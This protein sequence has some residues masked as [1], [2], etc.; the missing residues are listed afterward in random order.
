[1]AKTEVGIDTISTQIQN[2]ENIVDKID[3]I[4]PKLYKIRQ[5][6][7]AQK[8]YINDI[9]MKLLKDMTGN[10]EGKVITLGNLH[11]DGDVNSDVSLV[12][13]PVGDETGTVN[14]RKVIHSLF[15]FKHDIGTS[16]HFTTEQIGTEANRNNGFNL[17]DVVDF[18]TGLD[19]LL[20]LDPTIGSDQSTLDGFLLKSKVVGPSYPLSIN[21]PNNAVS[22]S[23][24]ATDAI[25]FGLN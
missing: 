3:T 18:T 11:F 1:M 12:G 10:S 20:K 6:A 4:V 2:C 9:Q 19:N 25:G 8:E 17:K 15:K 24:T 16:K 5:Q 13:T 21:G 22:I 23:I 14:S 7:L